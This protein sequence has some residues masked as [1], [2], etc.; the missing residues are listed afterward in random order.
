MFNPTEV[1]CYFSAPLGHYLMPGFLCV[2]MGMR[3]SE[4]EGLVLEHW[5]LL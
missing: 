1:M 5:L 2:V 4:T 3:I